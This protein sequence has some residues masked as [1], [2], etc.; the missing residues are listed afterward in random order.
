[1]INP[2]HATESTKPPHPVNT[3]TISGRVLAKVFH[4]SHYKIIGSCA[5]EHGH[6]PPKVSF[7]AA[8]EQFLPDLIV[9]VSN[10]PEE[11]PWLEARALYENKANRFA[12]QKA[13]KLATGMDLGFGNDSSQ[14]TSLHGNDER[15]RV[16]D[17]I[18]SPAAFYRFPFLSLKPE[19]H[20]GM[21]YYLS[22]LDAVMDRTEAAELVYMASHPQLLI[23]HDIGTATHIWGTEIP[24]LMR[25]TQPYNFRASVV[26]AMHAVDIV[27]NQN[28]LHVTKSTANRCGQNC[29]VA[30]AVFDPNNQKVIWQEVYPNNRTFRPG[31]A[32]DFGIEDDKKGNGNYVF[33]VWRKYRGCVQHHGNLIRFLTFPKV[34]QPQKR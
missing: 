29:V 5:W 13:Y 30:N 19:T 23:N 22:E 11:N 26:A 24:R 1:M 10:K 16:V 28:P 18:G 27:T 34:G 6:F 7:T 33:V 20:F 14:T 8:V 32:E 3:F 31:D 17:V 25:V 12:Y 4:N 15:T 21:P 9:T 2:T